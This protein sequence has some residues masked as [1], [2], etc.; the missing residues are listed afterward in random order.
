MST[1]EKVMAGKLVELQKER[2]IAGT[3]RFRRRYYNTAEP[4]LVYEQIVDKD[5]PPGWYDT[6]PR[7]TLEETLANLRGRPKEV[8]HDYP[9]KLVDQAWVVWVDDRELERFP[10]TTAG[11]GAAIERINAL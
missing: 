11:L 6:E 9:G 8:V 2:W 3:T 4:R 7:D 1:I 10:H 5:P